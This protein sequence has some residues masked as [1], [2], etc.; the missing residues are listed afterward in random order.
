MQFEYDG[1][2]VCLKGVLP[3]ELLSMQA[4][5]HFF[6][7]MD[8]GRRLFVQ[9]I[10][11]ESEGI[12]FE[13]PEQ[14]QGILLDFS[15]VFDTPKGLPPT[16]AYNHKIIL[17]DGTQP[18]S[19]RPYHLQYYQKTE[20]KKIVVELLNSRVIRPSSSPFSSHILLVRKID[21]A[22]NYVLITMHLT[23]RL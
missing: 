10:G 6:S 20:I 8:R 14:V 21:V 15:Q 9:L 18:I 1:V 3:K 5:K 11:A 17:K 22:K 12:H 4:G 19:T 13:L 16:L 7:S 2:T 23:R